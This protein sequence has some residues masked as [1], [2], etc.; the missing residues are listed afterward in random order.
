MGLV[1]NI[2][3]YSSVLSPSHPTN[4]RLGGGGVHPVPALIPEE[5]VLREVVSE[6]NCMPF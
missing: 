6:R 3:G 4:T 5:R 2:R 1:D